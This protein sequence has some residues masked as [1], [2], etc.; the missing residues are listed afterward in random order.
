MVGRAYRHARGEAMATMDFTAAYRCAALW[1][2][3]HGT[4]TEETDCPDQ[5]TAALDGVTTT[6]V[7]TLTVGDNVVWQRTTRTTWGRQTVPDADLMDPMDLHEAQQVDVVRSEYTDTG[8]L[9][10]ALMDLG[11]HVSGD[12]AELVRYW[13]HAGIERRCQLFGPTQAAEREWLAAH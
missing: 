4:V 9:P 7:T 5:V 12:A 1:I 13:G 3:E 8:E 10:A 6:A 2:G 11:Q